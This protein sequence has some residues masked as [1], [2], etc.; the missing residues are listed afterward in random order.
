MIIP[1]NME[2]YCPRCRKHT[3][4]SVSIYRKGKERKLAA[5]RRRYN[6][7]LK[8]YGGQPRPIQRKTAKTTKK[9]TVQLSCKDCGHTVHQLGIRLRK[10]E[11]KA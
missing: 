2:T 4:H 9:M 3:A 1:K 8:G 5:G 7:K 10:L 6:K 11:I